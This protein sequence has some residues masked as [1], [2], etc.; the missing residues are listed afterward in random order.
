MRKIRQRGLHRIIIESVNEK[1]FYKEKVMKKKK[2]LSF[3]VCMGLC[4]AA[5]GALTA[6]DNDSAKT[7][8]EKT[9]IEE[10]YA[11]YVVHAEAQG[12]TPLSYEDWLKA[13]KGDKG[14]KGD[15]GETG[16][17]GVTPHIG[18]NG[19]WFIGDTDTG[20]K[21][22]GTNGTNGTNGVNG[23]AGEKGEKGDEG[24]GIDRIEV[25]Y[26]Y[27]NDGN[28][29]MVYRV[30]YKGENEPEIIRVAM[31]KKVTYI[32]YA[33]SEVFGVC[34]E[35]DEKPVLKLYV[36]YEVG[37]GEF[38]EIT[39]D[40][41]VVDENYQKPDFTKE[42]N[43]SAEVKYKGHTT[44]INIEVRENCAN[45]TFDETVVQSLG[46]AQA[47]VVVESSEDGT[48]GW[49]YVSG[50][51]PDAYVADGNVM[52]VSASKIGGGGYLLF[53]AD[54]TSKT[55]SFYQPAKEDLL[56][57]YTL[58]MYGLF[59]VEVYAPYKTDGANVAVISG[60]T[61]GED[62]MLVVNA[63]LTVDET[64]TTPVITKIAI[65]FFGMEF[66]IDENDN[67]IPGGSSG[68]DASGE[69]VSALK[70]QA[71][72]EMLSRYKE[73]KDKYGDL[74]KYD[75]ELNY[76][77]AAIEKETTAD[78]IKKVLAQFNDLCN[79]IESEMSGSGDASGE[80]L[81]AQKEQVLSA[82]DEQW[83]VFCKE[84]GDL[85]KYNEEYNNI[86]ADIEKA[87]TAA[88]IENA[89][90]QFEELLNR[91]E[92]EMSGSGEEV[93]AEEPSTEEKA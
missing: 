79:Q 13:I 47:S 93:P 50:S 32:S 29:T 33:G 14:D 69:D 12:E 82:I 9:Q 58:T 27:D 37:Y 54:E 63:S 11:T 86:V 24:R 7:P 8:V 1:I 91:I 78:N 10:V 25:D 3:L 56:G 6:C 23:A 21:A 68:G 28:E 89:L 31:P 64:G 39:D 83:I 65:D 87:T 72:A 51:S 60:K 36:T 38:V 92:K 61:D 76:I 4:A 35:N 81:S 85:S 77:M 57:S 80:D 16:E 52:L 84:Y 30:Y 73:L 20:V 62:V 15:K 71:K 34:G 5:G 46:L 55:I 22:A 44:W 18:E 2:L 59:S 41:Y 90:A 40:M 66:T 74:S 67:L 42:G 19:N 17:N 75:D 53:T 48:S 49:I 45:Y 43:Y 70:K 88:D 26:E